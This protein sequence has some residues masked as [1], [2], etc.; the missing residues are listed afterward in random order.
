MPPLIGFSAALGLTLLLL[1]LVVYTGL[2]ARRRAHLIGVAGALL[3]LATAI[4]YAEQLGEHYDLESAGW[5]KDVHLLMAKLAVIA[6]LLPIASGLVTLRRPKTRP[7]HRRLAFLTLFLTIAT[8]VTGTIML[9]KATPRSA[10][11]P[12]LAE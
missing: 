5:I 6:Y 1:G 10:A 12:L 3:A 8:A 7:L 11:P 4:Y 9:Y 2:R